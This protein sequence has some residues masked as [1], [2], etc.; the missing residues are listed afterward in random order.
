VHD[1]VDALGRE[2]LGQALFSRG[3]DEI[4]LVEARLGAHRRWRGGVEAHDLG[5]AWIVLQEAD[6][7]QS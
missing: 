6:Q 7:I 3:V 1:R 5:D 4:E 2:H